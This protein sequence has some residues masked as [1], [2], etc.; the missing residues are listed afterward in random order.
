MKLLSLAGSTLPAAATPPNPASQST[1]AHAADPARRPR[2]P[3]DAAVHF[4]NDQ[5][6]LFIQMTITKVEHIH[7]L[8]ETLNTYASQIEYARRRNDDR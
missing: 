7:A 2:L 5:A 8:M 3:R 1:G 4:S 6:E